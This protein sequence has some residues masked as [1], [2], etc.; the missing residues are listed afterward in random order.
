MKQKAKKGVAAET[1][2]VK[3]TNQTL[4]TSLFSVTQKQLRQLNKFRH[5]HMRCERGAIGG[6]TTYCFSPTS[7]GVVVVLKCHCGKQ[8]DVSD[9]E[10]W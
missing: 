4:Y 7:L 5:D 2:P 9:Y 10:D 6:A 1:A 8:I 3:T